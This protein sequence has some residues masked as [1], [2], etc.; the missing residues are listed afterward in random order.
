MFWRMTASLLPRLKNLVSETHEQVL[1]E[2][3]SK[4]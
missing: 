3:M 1:H 4:R 2:I